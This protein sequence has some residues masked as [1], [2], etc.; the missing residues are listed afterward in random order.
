MDADRILSHRP[1]FLTQKQREDYF[2]NGYIMLEAAIPARTIRDLNDVT[3]SFVEKSRSVPESNGV[4]DVDRGHTADNPKLRRLS[5]PVDQHEAYWNFASNGLM[6]DIAEDLVGPDVKFHHSKLNFKWAGAGQ[7]VKWHQDIQAWPHTDYSP[8]T[9]G[10]YLHDT[11]LEMG[12]LLCI[13]ESQNGELFDHFDESGRWVGHILDKDLDRVDTGRAETLMGPAGSITIHNCRTVHA[14]EPNLSP[15]GR[16]LLLHTYSS[17]DSFPYTPNPI[18]SPHSG[19]VI[20][21][22]RPR[23]A[24]HD[25]RP[26]IVPPDWSGGYGSIFAQQEKTGS[27]ARA[28]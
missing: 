28:M 14:S 17:G 12:P 2:Q 20:R 21:G 1:K 11:S 16:P 24:H 9:M 26:C 18:P 6:A 27:S 7:E 25:P 10:I 15:I 8:L 22:Q 5:S 13:P 4:F 23:W 3:Q 19:T